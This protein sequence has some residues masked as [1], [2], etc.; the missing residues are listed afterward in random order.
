MRDR[1]VLSVPLF[2]SVTIVLLVVAAAEIGAA[3]GGVLSYR[4]HARV[5]QDKRELDNE[6][7]KRPLFQLIAEEK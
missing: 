1:S 2:F 5:E 7:K 6:L 4:A 3:V